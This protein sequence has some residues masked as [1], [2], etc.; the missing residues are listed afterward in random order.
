MATYSYE[1]ST[2]LDPVTGLPVYDSEGSVY[3]RSDTMFTTPLVIR[4]AD[5]TESTIVRV[6]NGAS[7]SFI[8]DD[9]GSVIWRDAAGISVVISAD[10]PGIPPAGETGQV[11]AKRS[12]A[13][14]DVEWVD[15]ATPTSAPV[16]P[17]DV[18]RTV[19]YAVGS[20]SVRPSLDPDVLVFWIADNP[21]QYA[22]LGDVWLNAPS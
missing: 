17:G 21:P 22:L 2:V 8:I 9:H 11:L 20:G 14:F 3:A 10:L 19:M 4:R 18:P 12:T 1:P 16:A 7:E 5:G 13:D 6:K 15:S